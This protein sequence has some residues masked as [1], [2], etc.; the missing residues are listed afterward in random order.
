MPEN[1][2]SIN[3][4]LHKAEELNHSDPTE[5]EKMF[6]NLLKLDLDRSIWFKTQRGLAFSLCQQEKITEAKQIYQHLLQ[7]SRELN[8]DEIFA[9]ANVGLARIAMETG[10]LK[11]CAEYSQIALKIYRNLNLI[12]QEITTLNIIAVNAYSRGDVISALENFKTCLKIMPNTRTPAYSNVL[13][14]IALTY[15]LQ[16]NLEKAVEYFSKAIEAAKISGFEWVLSTH[17]NNLGETLC[18]LGEYNQAKEHFKIAMEIAKNH[19]DLRNIAL[20]KSSYAQYL[21]ETGQLDVAYQKLLEAFQIHEKINDPLSKIILL[22]NFANYWH[23]KG[24][25]QKAKFNLEDAWRIIKESGVQESAIEVLIALVEVYESTGNTEKAY[26]Y[27]LI[28]HQMAQERDSDLARTQVLTQRG[29][30]LVNQKQFHEAEL[31]LD[32]AIWLARRIQHSELEYKSEILLSRNYLGQY[33]QD[34]KEIY[35]HKSLELITDA[36]F[37][38]K[39]QKLIPRYID[40]LIIEG[41]LLTSTNQEEK[42]KKILT[43]AKTL[44]NERGMIIQAQT[45]QDRLL[46]ILGGT[47]TKKNQKPFK[48]MVLSL[49]LDEISRA[50]ATYLESNFSEGDLDETFMA[51]FSMDPETGPKI[52]ET[53]NI[54]LTD[55]FWYRQIYQIA[56]LY[57][58]SLIQS[59]AYHEGLFGPLP[60][61]E[62]NLRSIIYTC[63]FPSSDSPSSILNSSNLSSQDLINSEADI[64][65]FCM[66]FPMGMI[67]LF[68]DRTKVEVIFAKQ[69]KSLTSFSQITKE[70][71]KIM[72][73]NIIAEIIADLYD[74]LTEI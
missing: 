12:E 40:I 57:S 69:T 68:Y 74:P 67:P 7:Q 47:T 2:P 65:L 6:R 49:I 36:K 30:I 70:F 31:I 28:A 51:V 60:F 24:H 15:R 21:I 34:F 20:V 9:D 11:K 61:G 29:L 3:Q 14:N 71:L 42:A 32:D 63:K 54:D 55:Q 38:A 66:V 17:E 10:E 4:L 59:Q 18:L 25:L 27:L 45:A 33:Q 62:T 39:K 26:E 22:L 48:K 8:L 43:E 23:V 73:E 19:N 56:S 72:H 5:A 1:E 50:T 13:N 46:L 53:E 16:G 35:I 52:L 44:A 64:V 37:I 58:V 41:M